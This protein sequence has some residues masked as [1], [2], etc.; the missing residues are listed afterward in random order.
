MSRF[1]GKVGFSETIQVAPSVYESVITERFYSGDVYKNY[2]KLENSGSVNDN[3]NVAN[4][5]SI[6]SDPY[7]LNAFDSIRYVEWLGR[8]WEVSAV[9]EEYPRL[10]LTIGGVYNGPVAEDEQP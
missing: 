9:L 4:E 1:Y 2:R 5:I 6:I 10:R 8:L 3:V 7:A